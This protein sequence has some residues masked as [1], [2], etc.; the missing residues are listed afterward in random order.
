M[1]RTNKAKR[2]SAGDFQDERSKEKT[3][4]KDESRQLS[5][6]SGN[7]TEYRVKRVGS[8]KR[9]VLYKKIG[10]R[11]PQVVQSLPGGTPLAHHS[12]GKK[13]LEEKNEVKYRLPQ[14]A[15]TILRGEWI[16]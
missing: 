9:R 14:V 8:E 13:K 15:N 6:S 7:P 4:K 12:L 11:G 5:P 1:Y 16:L 10:P 3:R 2:D